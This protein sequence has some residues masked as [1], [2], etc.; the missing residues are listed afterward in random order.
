[1]EESFDAAAFQ[2]REK[3]RS[4]YSQVAEALIDLLTFDNILDLGCGNGFLM[5]AMLSHGKEVV[6]VEQSKA[7]L[8]LLPQELKDHVQIGDATNL[9]RIGSFDL[10]AC[11]EVAEHIQ[12]SKS[13]AL[14]KSIAANGKK[15]V[16]FTAASPYQGGHGH[17]NCRPQFY[18]M[19]EFRKLGF[20]ME[21]DITE[22]LVGKIG[23]LTPTKWLPLNS[24][25]FRHSDSK[26]MSR[27]SPEESRLP[28]EP[29]NAQKTANE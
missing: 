16:Y 27:K 26:S 12:P 22:K 9:G 20:D 11:V 25:V 6:G 1:M 3:Y 23:D 15:W 18:W 28:G 5:E 10:V 13:T 7:V 8:P 4:C 17:I 2:E 29:G 14:L 21:W 24:L 19:S